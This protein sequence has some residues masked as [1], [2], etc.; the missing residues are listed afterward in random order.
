MCKRVSGDFDVQVMLQ[1]HFYPAGFAVYATL[2]LMYLA[3]NTPMSEWS[4]SGAT[5]EL[6]ETIKRQIASTDRQSVVLTRLTV[7][8]AVLALIQTVA[9][10]I[11][12][13]PLIQTEKG[14]DAINKQRD[15]AQALS[16]QN[17]DAPSVPHASAPKNKP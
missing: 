8:M 16:Q 5:R 14:K 12:I 3:D 2:G 7:F 9:T 13:I 10:V 4:G 11:Q 1:S 15:I 17:S 6:H